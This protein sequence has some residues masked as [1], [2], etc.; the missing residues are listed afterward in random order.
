MFSSS[1]SKRAAGSSA[2]PKCVTSSALRGQ[3][4]DQRDRR[5]PML[6]V[7]VRRRRRREHRAAA[8]ADPRHVTAEGGA[9]RVVEVGHVVLGVT[10]RVVDAPS[11]RS[12]RRRPARARGPRARARS[13]PT[14]ASCRRRRSAS[15]CRSASTGRS[16]AAHRARGPRPRRPASGAR[17]P[18]SRRRDRGGCASAGSRGGTRPAS[19]SRSACEA[20]SGPGSTITSSCQAQQM[21]CGRPRC[22]TSISSR[23]ATPDGAAPLTAARRGCRRPSAPRGVPT[24]CRAGSR[25]S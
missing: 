13:R 5:A 10:R 2:R 1:S 4:A 6:E 9:G 16:G 25:R 14:A 18:R 21:T 20:H 23:P 19:A 7:D 17:A 12:A 22:I 8:D 11:R 15:R 24:R 3:L